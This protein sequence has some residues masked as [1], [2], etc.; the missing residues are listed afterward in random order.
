M[1]LCA[2]GRTLV[3]REPPKGSEPNSRDE[4]QL[5]NEIGGNSGL[6]SGI[7]LDAQGRTHIL[8]ETPFYSHNR[9]EN[10]ALTLLRE[11]SRGQSRI[12]GARFNL[13]IKLA[14]IQV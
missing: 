9:S 3:L 11:S 10:V 2:Q 8:A 14:E 7:P 6:T 12:S 5:A 13:R 4:I 1:A